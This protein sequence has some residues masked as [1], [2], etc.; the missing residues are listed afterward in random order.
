MGGAGA[1]PG[2]GELPRRARGG[3]LGLRGPH[4]LSGAGRRCS[5]KASSAA[6]ATRASQR[7]QVWPLGLCAVCKHNSILHSQ[8]ARW[9]AHALVCRALA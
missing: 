7:L 3:M 2:P 6:S 1:S 4:G 5:N 8:R 9:G